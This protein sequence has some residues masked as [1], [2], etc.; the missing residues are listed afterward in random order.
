MSDLVVHE[1]IQGTQE[2]LDLRKNYHTASEANAM[3][4]T[5]L[6]ISRT[7]L[8]ERKKTGITPEP[9]R[10]EKQIFAL[11]HKAEGMARPLVEQMI[12]DDLFQVVATRGKFLASFDG[13]T[14]FHD[15]AFEHKLWN[16]ALAESVKQGIVP[17]SHVW[18]L[19]QQLY[20]SEAERVLFVVSDGTPSKFV[21]CWYES[22]PV[23]RQQLLHGWEIFEQDLEKHQANAV[24]LVGEAMD[25]LPALNLPITSMIGPNNFDQ[26]YEL[27]VR[28]LEFINTDLKV[29]QD[30]AD[31]ENA[32][33]WC[34]AREV[35][36]VEEKEKILAQNKDIQAI[37]NAFDE[38]GN[39]A[40]D[41]RL[42]LENLV[43]AEKDRKKELAVSE[44]VA[45]IT[46]Y[47]QAQPFNV[48]HLVK[49]DA[50]AAVKGKKGAK[51]M[52]DALTQV[53][54]KA[55]ADIDM[56]VAKI[57]EG[58]RV[59]EA[60]MGD[61]AFLFT[62]KQ[63]IAEKFEGEALLGEV[64]RIIE[65]H[66]AMIKSKAKAEADRMLEQAATQKAKKDAEQAQLDQAPLPLSE[67]VEPVET[68]PN[69]IT[70][71]QLNTMLHFD[72]TALATHL[73]FAVKSEYSKEDAADM[74]E[75]MSAFLE[76]LHRGL[77]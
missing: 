22:D 45:E 38:L 43:K 35:F 34:K 71:E 15:I 4:G 74:I 21:S 8:L 60:N 68:D 50:K 23:K 25:T 6:H 76:S 2:W 63:E 77:K 67:F 24:K 64:T 42:L 58:I 55:K 56:V 37:I 69:V 39:Q 54:S 27:S 7:E 59:I 52:Q 41:K 75:S 49:Y 14:V 33:K 26:Y 9:T 65:T 20:V 57:T 1:V 11:G 70:A 13:L 31:A 47:L 73:C 18:Q 32:I 5:C 36:L 12:E 28:A 66:K 44:V 51:G 16:K 29:D 72:H 61:H 3:M 10:F 19:E 53:L 30:F 48:M 17:D 40:R 62:N 46:N